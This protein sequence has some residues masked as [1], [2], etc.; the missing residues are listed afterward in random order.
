MR[1]RLLSALILMSILG[2]SINVSAAEIGEQEKE[3]Q[4]ITYI[5]E[6]GE[7][8][9]TVSPSAIPEETVSPDTLP[10]GDNIPDTTIQPTETPGTS[11]LPEASDEPETE[12][13]V[14][15]EALPTL[16]PDETPTMLPSETPSVIPSLAPEETFA[17][18]MTPA[19]TESPSVT[20]EPTATPDMIPTASPEENLEDEISLD[21]ELLGAYT[22]TSMGSSKET[23]RSVSVDTDYVSTLSNTNTSG[24]YKFT[25]K[26][27]PGYYGIWFK[28]LSIN[29]SFRFYVYDS[30]DSSLWDS[31]NVYQNSESHKEIKL[32]KNKTYYIKIVNYSN[33]IGNYRFKINYYSDPEGDAAAEAYFLAAN[34]VYRTTIAAS[35][36]N[37]WYKIETNEAGHY[38]IKVKNENISSCLEF[39]IYNIYFEELKLEDYIYSGKTGYINLLL[40]G[41][42]AYYLQ[43][44]SIHGSYVPGNYTIQYEHLTDNESD[45]KENAYDLSMGTKYLTDLCASD[46]VDYYKLVPPYTGKYTINI[47]NASISSYLAYQFCTVYDE[48]LKSAY[49]Y[50]GRQDAFKIELT[51]GSPYYLRIN[52]SSGNYSVSYNF[53]F[54]FKD[55]PIKEGNWKYEAVS[56]V[57]DKG[58]MTGVTATTFEPDAFLT[59]AQFAS[60]LYRMAGEPYVSYRGVFNDVP[61]EKWFSKAV[62]W[63]YN[64]EIV[65]GYSNGSFGPNDYIT[66]EQVAAMLYRYSDYKGNDVS[67]RSSLSRFPDNGQVSRWAKPQVEWAVAR[68]VIS[69]K[70]VNG[71]LNLVPKGLATRAECA[72]MISQYMHN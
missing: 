14:S 33:Y 65:A 63:A 32:E 34:Q 41:N 17:P 19:G 10:E 25:T 2:T 15:P 24:W 1:K 12:P 71:S 7:L 45:T 37:D 54:P 18:G 44:N 35:G 39:S 5:E 55:V 31:Y 66:R 59:R 49:V 36:D 11:A 60:V 51:A 21:D 68:Q 4:N 47:K 9:E 58:I 30:L 38:Q 16:M 50:T 13:T 53:N 46:D 43:V 8:E 69:G 3:L 48:E 26:N 28:N 6:K 70:T 20:P 23:A 56:Y 67:I 57:N 61:K 52:N 72:A 22:E 29:G 40:E 42:T 64:K 27:E 62:I